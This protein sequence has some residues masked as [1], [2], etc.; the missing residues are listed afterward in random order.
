[1]PLDRINGEVLDG[2]QASLHVV[3]A[4]RHVAAMNTLQ[5]S[6]KTKNK[7]FGWT[8]RHRPLFDDAVAYAVDGFKDAGALF[9]VRF[10]ETCVLCQV[11]PK[12]RAVTVTFQRKIVDQDHYVTRVYEQIPKSAIESLLAAAGKTMPA[13]H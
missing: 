6:Y 8:T 4:P 11:Y 7:K 12:E 10:D 3:V 2:L 1:M 9:P 13:Q 5:V